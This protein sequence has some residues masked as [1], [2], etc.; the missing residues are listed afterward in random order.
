VQISRQRTTLHPS[1]SIP[2]VPLGANFMNGS[3]KSAV[4]AAVFH[5]L[6]PLVKLLLEAGVGVGEFHQL[7]K[8]AY[9]QV[10]RDRLAE[11]RPNISRISVLTG[12]SRGEVTTLLAQPADAEPVAGRGRHRAEDVLRGWWGDP[13]YVDKNGHP[14]RIPIRGSRRS[15]A[16][17]VKRY[18]GD[19]RTETLLNELIRVKAVQKHPDGQLQALSR[20]VATARWDVPGVLAIG[21]R[22]HDLLETLMHNIEHPNRP[23][24]ERFVVSH[25]VDPRHAPLLL[26]DIS[27]QADTWADGFREALS[28]PSR[29]VRPGRTA[30]DA[31]RLGIAIYMVEDATIVEPDKAAAK[32]PK[33]RAD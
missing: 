27:Q 5:M 4:V 17:L 24:Y 2:G 32:I 3:L 29:T 11:P 6:R 22:V 26:R 7:A 33:R 28:E 19:P 31:R 16:T 15:F 18:A 30:Q 12:I 23:R 21:E 8:R 13:A 9:V 25:R 20:T 1:L 10:A 14:L